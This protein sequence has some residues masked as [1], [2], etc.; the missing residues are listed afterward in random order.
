MLSALLVSAALVFTGADADFAFA[1]AT[2]LVAKCPA[3]DAGSVGGM[4]AANW[5]LDTASEA[6]VD[7]RRDRFRALARANGAQAVERTFTNLRAQFVK[8]SDAPWIVFV[9]HYDTKP[10]ANCPGANDGA[11]TTGLLI[12]LAAALSARGYDGQAN[13]MLIWLDGEECVASYSV[14][15][16]LWGSVRAAEEFQRRE[17][18]VRGVFCL[19][20]LGD[21]DLGITIPSN[22]SPTLMKVAKTAAKTVGIDVTCID[23]NVRDDHV[24]FLEAGYAA[25][26]LIDFCFGSAPGRNDWWHTPQDSV[27][28]IS[29]ESLLKAGRL[30]AEIVNLLAK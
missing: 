23:K 21:R 4:F 1:C 29:R 17:M 13:V 15:D 27:D 20:M 5:I 12:A 11:S 22:G 18:D 6:G 25:I 24:A 7:I 28:K 10:G 3:R 14:N 26:D 8:A 16:G 19:D 9:S 2:N 30:V